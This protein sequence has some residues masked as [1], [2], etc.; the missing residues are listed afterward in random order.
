MYSI[1]T[2]FSLWLEQC[3]LLSSPWY[4]LWLTL[5]TKVLS[6][7]K[8]SKFYQSVNSLI[9]HILL[10][11]TNVNFFWLVLTICNLTFQPASSSLQCLEWIIVWKHEVKVW[12]F[13]VGKKSLENLQVFYNSLKLPF[14]LAVK[15]RSIHCC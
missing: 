4:I 2:I 10:G 11:R 3:W 8:Y 6:N 5:F 12:L 15:S 13:L 9:F 1:P 7:C 14:D